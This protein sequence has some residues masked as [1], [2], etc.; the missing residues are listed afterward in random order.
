VSARLSPRKI[1]ARRREVRSLRPKRPDGS[2]APGYEM[3]TR[4]WFD[5]DTRWI[6]TLVPA[7][8]ERELTPKERV[9][10]ICVALFVLEMILLAV[11]VR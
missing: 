7:Q 6:H 4:K 11:V 1:K 10:L 3:F 9:T 2:F 5:G 8:S